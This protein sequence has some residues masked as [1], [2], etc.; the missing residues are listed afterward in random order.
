[1]K[2]IVTVALIAAALLLV[3]APANAGERVLDGALGGVS[4]AI[5]FGPVGL[6]AGGLTGFVAGPSIARGLGVRGRHHH[7]VRR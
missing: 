6:V 4:G 5:V 2:P 1:M 3:Q 7:Y